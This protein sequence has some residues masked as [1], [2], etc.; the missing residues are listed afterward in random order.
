MRRILTISTLTLLASCGSYQLNS[1]DGVERVSINQESYAKPQFYVKKYKPSKA[2]RSIAS[3]QDGLDISNKKAYFL[4]LYKQHVEFSQIAD[5][6]HKINSCPQFHN[7]LL[8]YEDELSNK[9]ISKTNLDF[10]EVLI[11]KSK[12][13]SY[14]V[15]SLPYKNTDL[16]SYIEDNNKW[17]QS[18]QIALSAIKSYT[19]GIRKEIETMCEFGNSNDYYIFENM[20]SYYRNNQDFIYS[21]QALPS[22]LKVSPIANIFLLESLKTN[23]EKVSVFEDK[24]LNKMNIPWFKNYLYEVSLMRNNKNK[25]FVLKD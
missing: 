8:T 11:D 9:Q 24:L 14:P 18:E 2:S 21:F 5:V 1:I 3:A 12:V 6:S 15:L 7:D 16:Y 4:S 13:T 10:R 17:D 22:V 25:R 23:S 20:I 19:S